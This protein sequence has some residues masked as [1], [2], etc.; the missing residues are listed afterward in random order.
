M[1]ELSLLSTTSHPFWRAMAWARQHVAAG[2]N[3]GFDNR[4]RQPDEVCV[5]QVSLQGTL[6][7]EENGNEREVPAGYLLMFQ[8]DEP[9]SYRKPPGQ[10]YECQWLTVTGAGVPEHWQAF[11]QRF[12][13]VVKIHDLVSLHSELD[14]AFEALDHAEQ[15]SMTQTAAA[16]HRLVMRLFDLAHQGASRQ[17]APVQRAIEHLLTQPITH[18]SVQELADRFGCSREHLARLF[19]QRTGQS[20]Q[21]Y[22]T[23][24][25]L[26][27]AT[28][29]LRHTDL[30]IRLIARQ[31]GFGTA[32]TLRRQM[33]QRYGIS[34]AQWRKQ[35]AM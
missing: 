35:D 11:R 6:L 25:R 27:R 28:Q 14:L 31:S 15:M 20:P 18:H 22:L 29:L 19:Q 26:Q 24:A 23:Q 5:I 30:P 21:Q 8:W 3:Y 4:L 10:A 9:S 1:P 2:Q 13:S 33:Q 32:H 34:P 17:H 12:G 7:F 16:L